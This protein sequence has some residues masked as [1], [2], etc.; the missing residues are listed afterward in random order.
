MALP[1]Q[2]KLK[3]KPGE[4]KKKTALGVR[5]ITNESSDFFDREMSNVDSILGR[6]ITQHKTEDLGAIISLKMPKTLKFLKY[7]LK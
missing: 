1:I 7:M 2:V 6:N 5:V 4:K 3:T